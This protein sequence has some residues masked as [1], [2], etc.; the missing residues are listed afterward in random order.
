MA[1]VLDGHKSD[2][3]AI[4]AA[5]N[6]GV[7]YMQ[8]QELEKA[9]KLLQS[10][11]DSKRQFDRR[12]EAYLNLGWTIYSLAL[13][14]KPE[15]LPEADKAFAKLL[16]EFPEGQKRDQALFFQGESLYLQE[17]RK[18]SEKAYR[19]LILDFPDSP[20]R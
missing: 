18:E 3:K 11:V 12:E 7:C 10:V 20:L 13:D 14:K 1:E 16:E 8:L 6:L 5:Y 17:N 19:Q 2:P 15:L 4:D 9:R